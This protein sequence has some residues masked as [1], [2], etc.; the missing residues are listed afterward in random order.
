MVRQVDGK[1]EGLKRGFL[2][3]LFSLEGG[4]RISVNL[5]SAGDCGL[6]YGLIGEGEL[7][8]WGMGMGMG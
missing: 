2:E 1:G 6:M 4:A 8:S 5:I 3:H 7:D